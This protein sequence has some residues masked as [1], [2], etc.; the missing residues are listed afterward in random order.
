M[1]RFVRALLGTLL[2][3]GLL[4]A[5]A[6]RPIE[7]GAGADPTILVSIDGFRADYL[8]LG[9]TPELSRLAAQG[10]QGAIRPSFPSKTFPNHYTLVTGLRPDHHGVVDN[11]MRDPEIPGVTFKLSSREAVTDRR[12]WDDGEPVWVTAEKAGRRTAVMFW[13]GSE[14]PIHGVRPTEWRTYDAGVSAVGR[15]DQVL[16]WLDAPLAERPRFIALYF[17]AVDTAGHNHGPRSGEV[18]AALQ[19]TDAAL[20][21]L[22]EGLSKRGLRANIV[23]VSDHGMAE[24]SSDRIIRLDQIVPADAGETLTMGAFLTYYPAA[25]R[26]AEARAALLAPHDHMTCWPKEKIPA[27][28]HYGTHR[29]V[30]PIVCLPETGWEIVTAASLARW[31]VKGGDHGFDPYALEMRALFLGVG[32]AFR[33]GTRTPLTDNVDVYPVLMRLLAL[34]PRPND[35]GPALSEAALVAQ[36]R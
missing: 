29:R 17:D 23:V 2:T 4:A 5:C 31:G 18:K 21:R 15:V 3:C 33:P 22:T 16:A 26:E 10:A 25:G 9:V 34:E 35:G 20:A 30:A 13:P 1:I 19:E 36:S 28:Y 12:W 6:T 27:A 32:P 14:A 24:I 11:N 7:Q 8:D